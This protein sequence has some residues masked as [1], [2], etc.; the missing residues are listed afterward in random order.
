MH[1][2]AAG[3]IEIMLPPYLMLCLVLGS[4]CDFVSIPFAMCFNTLLYWKYIVPM[5]C[6]VNI[7]YFV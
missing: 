3:A 4:I 1:G 6:A 7:I 5:C 2:L